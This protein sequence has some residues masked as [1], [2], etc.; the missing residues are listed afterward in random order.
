MLAKDSDMK[1]QKYQ[2]MDA[3]IKNLY[4]KT[5]AAGSFIRPE[6]LSIPDTV[7]RND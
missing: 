3:R 1:V 5:S 2:A 4:S 6:I 7:L